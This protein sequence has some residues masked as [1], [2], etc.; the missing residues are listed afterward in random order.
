MYVR[1]VF[2]LFYV[3]RVV[4]RVCNLFLNFKYTTKSSACDLNFFSET[5]LAEAHN[6]ENFHL[7]ERRR[8]NTI[9]SRRLYTVYSET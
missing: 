5:G 2:S 4:V 1:Y 3:T 8:A 6:P 7:S 9:P